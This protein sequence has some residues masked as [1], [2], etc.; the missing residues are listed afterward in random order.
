MKD[1]KDWSTAPTHGGV[2]VLS[3]TQSYGPPLVALVTHLMMQS[4]LG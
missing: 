3:S 4:E 1:K 2:V